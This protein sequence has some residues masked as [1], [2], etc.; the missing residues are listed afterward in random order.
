[1]KR[2]EALLFLKEVLNESPY[3]SPDAIALNQTKEPNDYT[4]NIKEI[5]S[6]QT[7]RDIASKHNF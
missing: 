5:F 7:I 1:M 2:D 3:M 6:S 4:V